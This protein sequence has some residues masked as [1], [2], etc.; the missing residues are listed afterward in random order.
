MSLLFVDRQR[1]VVQCSVD[2]QTEG[3]CMDKSRNIREV[4]LVHALDRE[5]WWWW[6]VASRQQDGEITG[7]IH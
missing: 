1:P 6:L 4:R 3:C 7:A 5:K 2:R